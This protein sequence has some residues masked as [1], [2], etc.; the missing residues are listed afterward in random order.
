MAWVIYLFGSGIAFF[1]GVGLVLAGVVLVSFRR[2]KWSVSIATLAALLG[3]I[4]VAVSATPLPYWLYGLAGALTMG[5]LVVERSGSE[6]ARCRRAWARGLVAVVWLA[7]ILLEI[8]YQVVPTLGAMDRPPLHIFADSVS[9]GTGERGVPTWPRLLGRSHS[10]DV[11]DHSIPGATVRMALRKAQEVAPV[12]G[13]VLLEIG[14]NDLLG[15]TTAHDFEGDLDA[16]LTQVSGPGRVVVMFEL[17][18]LPFANE[19]GRVQRRLAHRHGVA[20]IPKRVFAAVLTADGATVDSIHLSREGQELMAA[21]VWSL[22]RP[23]YGE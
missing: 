17:P 8:P 23:A 1:A 7:A 2:R 13:L 22:I 6:A 11:R 9:A 4:L 14:G 5:W 12:E 16:L 15:S 19:F 3:L 21:T 18:L 10:I 20:L